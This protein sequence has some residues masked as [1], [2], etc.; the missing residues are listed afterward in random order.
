MRLRI[1]WLLLWLAGAGFAAAP[2]E[3][4]APSGPGWA[5][6]LAS[7]GVR[8]GAPAGLARL[9]ILTGAA[10]G[11]TAGEERI[12][13][14]R[15][16]DARRPDL[17]I[18]W[19]RPLEIPRF[20]LPP[21]AAVF[22]KERWSGAPVLAGWREGDRAFLWSATD[23]GPRGFERYPYLLQ[24]LAD[25]GLQPP[26]RGAHLW[27]FF[28]SSYRLRA[29]M[30]LMASRWRKAGIA[31][32]HVAAW[33]YWEPDPERDAYLARLIETCHRHAVLVYAW[34][35]FPHVSEK[36]WRDHPQWREKTGLLG[37]AHLDWRKLMNLQNAE[38][39]R[40]VKEGAR[41]LAARFDWDGIN[42]GELYFESLEGYSNPARF[43]PFND[44]VRREFRARAGFDP[45]E[46]FGERANDAPAMRQFLDYRAELARR[47]QDEW[48]GVLSEIRRSSPGLDLVL[49]HI[50]DRFDTQIRDLLGADASKVLPLLDKHDFTFLVED[51][52][53][54]WHLGPQRYPEI[55]RRYQALTPKH[56]RLGIDINIVERYQDVYPTKQQTGVELFQLV[57]LAAQSFERVAL[58]F[59]NSILAPDIPLLA[60]AAA[61]APRITPRG[62][63][64]EVESARDVLV[65]WKGPARVNGKPWPMWDGEYVRLPPGIHRIEPGEAGPQVTD[66]NAKLIAA[67]VNERGAM[68]EYE[69]RSRAI[70][71]TAAGAQMLPPGRRRVY[72]AVTA[73]GS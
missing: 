15:I 68:I 31:A 33:H 12:T 5:E 10:G 19:D 35:E 21:Q 70:V 51:P 55:A 6:A 37:E 42:L 27:A 71:K 60:A 4:D 49:T 57:H 25:L 48:L 16:I 40:A 23:P 46:L 26:A 7:I 20:A 56:D 3:V 38:C 58:Y 2:L 14:R 54:I 11:V 34:L 73:G 65:A 22:A 17:E 69:S 36:F 41:A 62:A 13:V 8:A 45:V 29:D 44:D 66:L 67:E 39:A 63:G 72:L 53:T 43:T 32:I 18:Y 1:S 28:D 61:G 59:E 9:T 30:D 52:A 24:A 50:D 64:L 47:M